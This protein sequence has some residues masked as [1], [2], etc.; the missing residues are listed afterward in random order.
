MGGRRRLDGAADVGDVGRPRDAGGPVAG[1]AASG[2]G[3]RRRTPSGRGGGATGPSSAARRTPARPRPDRRAGGPARGAGIAWA[4]T[5]AAPGAAGQ[6]GRSPFLNQRGAARRLPDVNHLRRGCA[7]RS[8]GSA[9]SPRH[10]TRR[11]PRRGRARAIRSATPMKRIVIACDGTW[12]RLDAARQTNVAKLAEAVLPLAPDGVPQ[13]VCHLDGVGSGRGT[14][15]LA[16]ALDRALGGALGLG[17]E[18]TLVEAY[19]FLVLTYAPGDDIQLF[20]FSRGAY[21]AR[22]LAGLIRA[23]GILERAHADAVAGGAGALPGNATAADGDGGAR[24]SG[25]GTR[26]TSP[27]GAAEAAWRAARGLP[28]GLPLGIG[29]LGVWDTVGRARGAGASGAGGAAQPRARLP[30]HGAVADGRGGAACGGDRRA[31]A[32][33]PADALGQPRR[34]ERRTAPG[35]YAQRW[36]PGDHGSV[37]GGGGVDGAVGR[38]A[39]LG[40]RGRGRG[41]AGARPGGGRRA[42]RAPA[43]GA[44]RS[45]ARRPGLLRR[46]LMLDCAD[47]P[48]PARLGE[49]AEAAVRRWRGDPGYRPAAL[50]AGGG[51]A[52]RRL[53]HGARSSMPSRQAWSRLGA[54]AAA[55]RSSAAPS[56]AARR[57]GARSR[58]VGDPDREE[59]A[60]RRA[61]RRAPRR[62]GA[63]PRPGCPRSRRS[64]RRP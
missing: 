1:A 12:S 32:E 11:S 39:A 7:S 63:R 33:L 43:T 4:G 17:L 61:R 18:A 2:S 56:G 46:L 31:A 8:A 44:G 45:T 58:A 14:G 20:G 52:R 34:A 47:R 59:D 10:P 35:A 27:P 55:S 25:R 22:S 50:G 40:R 48:G 36:F 26:R 37:G 28:G 16:R 19:R 60:P 54:A 6:R 38:R 23:C 51:G 29:Y 57:C 41:G 5:L 3:G 62:R 49:L 53:I 42:G 21:T 15:R 13:I 24:P 9:H 30:R 64:A